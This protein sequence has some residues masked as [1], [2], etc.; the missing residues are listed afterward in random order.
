MGKREETRKPFATMYFLSGNR[1]VR[2]LSLVNGHKSRKSILHAGVTKAQKG[3][4]DN[5]GFCTAL[6]VQG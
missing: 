5:P 3:M 4:D 1:E 2:V 6:A